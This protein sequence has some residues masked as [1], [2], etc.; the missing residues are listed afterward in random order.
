MAEDGDVEYLCCDRLA[1]RTLA[2]ATAQKKQ[3]I[4][5]GYNPLLEPWFNEVL[6]I[7]YEKGITI[8][9]SFGAAN[10]SAAGTA[11]AEIAA[12]LGY[13][14]M[15]IAAITGDDVLDGIH[16]RELRNLDTGDP[17]HLDE[18]PGEVISANAYIGIDPM[19]EALEA[20]ADVI[21]GG[22]FGDMS[23]Y[24]A[25]MMYEFGWDDEDVDKKAQGTAVAHLLECGTHSTGGNLAYPGYVKVPELDNLGLPLVEIDEEGVGIISKPD[26]TGGIVSEFSMTAQ[27]VYEVHDPANYKTPD[28]VVDMRNV[29]IE[30]VSEDEVKV[31]GAEGKPKPEDF[32]VLVGVDEGYMGEIESGWGG[33][34]ALEKTDL[35][36]D[37]VIRPALAEYEDVLNEVR[38]DRIGVDAIHSAAAPDPTGDPNEVRLRIAFKT[39]EEETANEILDTLEPLAFFT[40]IGGGGLKRNVSSYV[41][42]YPT[43][44]PRDKATL[45]VDLINVNEKGVKQ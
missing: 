37:E 36:I 32:K 31:T 25:A 34:D 28:V 8:L 38:I 33:R 26:G 23:P 5:E 6:P 12:E 3:G 19:I 21:I 29:E 15:R 7:C 1:E 40:A 41:G 27:L 4:S 20:D 24:L 2:K 35:T 14:D 22:R 16:D 45:E 9:G 30:Q 39:D 43:L 10:P 44:L 18:L 17:L 13:T 11:V 42:T